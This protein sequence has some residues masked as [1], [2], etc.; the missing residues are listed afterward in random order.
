MVAS[1]KRLR[2]AAATV[3]YFEA[4]GYYARGDP[5][6]RQ[7]SRW[8]GGGAKDC[9]LYNRT[10]TARAFASVL[11][12]HVPRTD[13]RLGRLRDG[14]HQHLP[15]ID[16]TF[17]APKSFSLEALVYA[18]PHTRA[19]LLNAHDAA[20]RAALDLLERE[21]LQTRGY[22]PHHPAAPAGAGA[23]T[24]GCPVPPLHQPEPGP[25]SPHP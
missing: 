15:G 19:R 21:L 13:V 14:E 20:V 4:D 1:V 9:G 12:G 6:H 8:H 7:A 24:A 25:A 5:E 16:I 17:S 10:V 23:R 11:E 22:G 2:I 18:P 3:E